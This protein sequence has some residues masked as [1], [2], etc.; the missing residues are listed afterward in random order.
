MEDEN[1]SIT[2]ATLWKV[3]AKRFWIL[4]IVGVVS[5]FA[6]FAWSHLTFVPQY[7]ATA[8]IFV[9]RPMPEGQATNDNAYV[10]SE[11]IMQDCYELLQGRTVLQEVVNQLNLPM[12]WQEL[13]ACVSTDIPT[14]SRNLAVSVI[15]DS[16]EEAVRI[17]N[18]LCS[19]GETTIA[20]VLGER[21]ARFY[22]PAELEPL[23]CNSPSLVMNLLISF[24]LMFVVYVVF[25]VI[26][27]RNEYIGNL[28]EIEKRLNIV[29]LGDIP[30]AGNGRNTDGYYYRAQKVT[31]KLRN[32]ERGNR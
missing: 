15:A 24:V 6:V 21:H 28:V 22:E 27:T 3:L 10:V 23:P 20:E 4:L 31:E 7:R 2:L 1:R 12:T 18:T 32:D 13:G 17:V 19:V 26:F 11:M 5:F 8:K 9:L 16:P 30:N 14:D 29:V 25:V